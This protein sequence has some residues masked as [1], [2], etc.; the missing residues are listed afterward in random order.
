MSVVERMIFKNAVRGD[1]SARP[2]RSQLGRL[3]GWHGL[4]LQSGVVPLWENG[5]QEYFAI[6][7]MAR[8]AEIH[9]IEFGI[10]F[11]WGC[12]YLCGNSARSVSSPGVCRREFWIISGFLFPLCSVSQAALCVVPSVASSSDAHHALLRGRH[13][14]LAL[15]ASVRA[16]LTLLGD[17]SVLCF[18]MRQRGI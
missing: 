3:F 18:R 12:G 8:M 4:P 16:V 5:M 17:L 10:R 7:A 14:L 2:V 1:Q 6:I 15:G 9:G 11:L 13:P